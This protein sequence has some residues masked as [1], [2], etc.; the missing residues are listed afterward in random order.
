MIVNFTI[1]RRRLTEQLK[2]R[3]SK[4]M[5]K[6]VFFIDSNGKDYGLAS[7][8]ANLYM[9]RFTIDED[10]GHEIVKI[11]EVEEFRQRNPAH[12]SDS[13]EEKKRIGMGHIVFLIFECFAAK[14]SPVRLELKLLFILIKPC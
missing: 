8:I 14:F 9:N 2:A 13:V 6:L 5:Q 10:A 4:L 11:Y 12:Q 3:I 7:N 1:R